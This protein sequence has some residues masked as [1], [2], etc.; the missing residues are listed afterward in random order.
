MPDA[1]SR[2]FVK[3]FKPDPKDVLMLMALCFTGLASWGAEHSGHGHGGWG[4][5]LSPIHVFSL[6]GVFGSVLAAWLSQSPR[7]LTEEE[8]SSN[9]E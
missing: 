1:R 2:R 6:L 7:K 3:K 4:D 9:G 8:G 5:L